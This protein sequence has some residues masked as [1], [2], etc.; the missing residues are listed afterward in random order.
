MCSGRMNKEVLKSFLKDLGSSA[1]RNIKIGCCPELSHA[2][3]FY[4]ERWCESFGCNVSYYFTLPEI[5]RIEGDFACLV[6]RTPWGPWCYISMYSCKIF[7]VKVIRDTSE[8]ERI[9]YL[10]EYI[11]NFEVE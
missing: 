11:R 7:E 2:E 9:N 1:A 3:C 10:N 4:I 5:S 8:H 6:G